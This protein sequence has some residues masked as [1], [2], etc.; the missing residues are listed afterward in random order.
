VRKRAEALLRRVVFYEVEVVG[1]DDVYELATVD[2]LVHL[3]WESA[4]ELKCESP[5]TIRL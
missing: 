5:R 2:G 4:L 3:P 1:H